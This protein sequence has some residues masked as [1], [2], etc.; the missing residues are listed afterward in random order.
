MLSKK[1]QNITPSFT[2]GISNKVQQ[3]KEKGIDIINLSIGEPDFKTPQKAK[4]FAIKAIDENK[5]KYDIVSG[6]K[7]LKEAIIEKLK[8]E[9]KITYTPEEIVVSSGAKHS[10]SNCLIALLNDSEEVLIPKPY[11]VSYPEMV[12]LVGAK[13]VFI[14]TQKDNS[15]KVT[16]D[17]ILNSLTDKTKLIILSNPSNP[18]GIVYDKKELEEIVDVCIEKNIY[19]LAD[20]IYEKICYSGDYTSVAS[21]SEKAKDIT[22]TVNGLSK[23]AAM[24]GWRIGYTASNSEIAKKMSSI[25]GHLVSHPCT[26]AQWAGV[27]A[28]KEC[29]DDMQ[30]MVATYKQRMQLVTS[31]LD[32]INELS[33]LKPQGAFYIFIDLSALKSKF[34]N[35]ESLSLAF[36]N[37]LLEEGKVAAVPGIAFGLDHYMRISYA[38]SDE[39]IKEGVKRISNFIKSL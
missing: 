33:Y 4:E 9:N 31:L 26:I 8:K 13:P 37:R 39:N 19:I 6:I 3:L 15:F 24:T 25:Q 2:I 14:E 34:K 22:I 36:C 28:L 27:G 29:E 30:E 18:T 38:C 21:I 20:E 5:T 16:K 7:P 12:K 32:E 17:E 11:W 1:A 10:I 23:S 35:E